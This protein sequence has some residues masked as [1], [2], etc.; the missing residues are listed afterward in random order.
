MR[1]RQRKK[2]FQK[3]MFNIHCSMFA[4]TIARQLKCIRFSKDPDKKTAYME[5]HNRF[6]TKKQIVRH[7]IKVH[8]QEAPLPNYAYKQ[9]KRRL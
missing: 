8:K 1:E 9:Y 6:K 4:S 7:I 5:L 3:S 2:N